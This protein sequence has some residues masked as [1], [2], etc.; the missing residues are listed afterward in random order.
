M[1][2]ARGLLEVE[3]MPNQR[4]LPQPK[5]QDRTKHPAGVAR[6]QLDQA[7]YQQAIALYDSCMRSA[8]AA[9]RQHT[10]PPT[11]TKRPASLRRI[12]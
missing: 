4:N 5:P 10:R 2:L 6:S 9:T 3:T 12:A 7:A 11:L 8:P 1:A